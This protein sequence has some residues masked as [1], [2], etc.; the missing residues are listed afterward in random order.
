[1]PGRAAEGAAQL[2]D[3]LVAQLELL[4]DAVEHVVDL[5]H[6]IAAQGRGEADALEVAGS[7]PTRRQTP[8]G[9]RRRR[10]VEPAGDPAR[11][12]RGDEPDHR[13]DQQGEQQRHA[14]MLPR[15]AP[16]VDRGRAS[17]V[18]PMGH[19]SDVVLLPASSQVGVPL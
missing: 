7:H 11:G 9:Q 15:P 3:L 18:L 2:G 16:T 14:S 12:D 13:Q 10:L 17:S 8:P 1:V 5:V 6:P 19:R 4:G